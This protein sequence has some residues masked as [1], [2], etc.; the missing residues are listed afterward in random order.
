MYV[1]DTL[2]VFANFG[3]IAGNAQTAGTTLAKRGAY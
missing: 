1:G 3:G 2:T